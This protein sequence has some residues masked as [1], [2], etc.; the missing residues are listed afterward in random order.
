MAAI[1]A[2]FDMAE[3]KLQRSLHRKKSLAKDREDYQRKQAHKQEKDSSKEMGRTHSVPASYRLARPHRAA[4]TVAR[5]LLAKGDVKGESDMPNISVGHV[6]F[7]KPSATGQ[8]SCCSRIA[9]EEKQA[10]IEVESDV[11]T[12]VPEDSDE[13]ED[14]AT[15]T[16]SPTL[17]FMEGDSITEE[18]ER[19]EQVILED[20]AIHDETQP[21]NN[22][23]QD[24]VSAGT[25]DETSK[26]QC[27]ADELAT[28]KKRKAEQPLPIAGSIQESLA[29]ERRECILREVVTKLRNQA[30]EAE[31]DADEARARAKEIEQRSVVQHPREDAFVR[32]QALQNEKQR[33]AHIRKQRNQAAHLRVIKE[34]A[35][36][37][38][39]DATALRE[40]AE[41]DAASM[42]AQLLAEASKAAQDQA[43]RLVEAE[44]AAARVEAEALK[45]DSLEVVMQAEK[46]K[47]ELEAEA[48]ALKIQADQEKAEAAEAK[49]AAQAVQAEA[50]HSAQLIRKGALE[51]AV[52]LK[53][54]VQAQLQE[55][56]DSLSKAQQ[57]A[58]EAAQREIAVQAAD[59]QRQAEA[60]AKQQAAASLK[61][62]KTMEQ[63][64]ARKI[65]KEAEQAR[66]H[67]Q[68]KSKELEAAK[69]Q[70]D[71]EKAEIRQQALS[72]AA[73]LR[74]KAESD[75]REAA[76]LRAQAE[77]EAEEIRAMAVREAEQL[78][79]KLH[80]EQVQD[81]ISSRPSSTEHEAIVTDA[82]VEDDI[83]AELEQDWHVLPT[84]VADDDWDLLV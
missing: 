80:A 68:L 31:R 8:R 38:L 6:E 52:A 5:S 50:E 69:A 44:L 20:P 7:F 60:V 30:R 82:A 24:T 11:E 77:R 67:E 72:E 62:V 76:A 2:D 49:A 22:E 47:A 12:V 45:L 64:R 36:L 56:M 59:A 46:T 61:L 73:A 28:R 81:Q 70:A 42:K 18:F 37:T 41:I 14:G 53:A 35:E 40:Q 83:V 3:H 34:K 71:K 65:R 84:E 13:T 23:A 57:E 48:H 15:A 58:E 33:A 26:V 63:Q 51:D 9:F 54:R 4:R 32:K 17:S 21:D 79:Q 39:R 55:K 27:V 10:R 16:S 25:E 78:I 29:A 1:F 66:R 43:S 74:T 75:A 19:E